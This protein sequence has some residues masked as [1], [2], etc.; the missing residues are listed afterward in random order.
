MP[1][2]LIEPLQDHLRIVQRTHEQDLARGYGQI[3]LPFARSK[4]YPNAQ[5]DRIWQW[6]FPAIGI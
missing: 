3:P 5:H 6:V 2:K 4:K 1:K